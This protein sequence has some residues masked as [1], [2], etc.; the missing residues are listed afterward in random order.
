MSIDS[1]LLYIPDYCCTF[2]KQREFIV[3]HR[4]DVIDARVVNYMVDSDHV[5]TRSYVIKVRPY[6]D[7]YSSVHTGTL[8]CDGHSAHR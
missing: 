4:E 7:R 3:F 5:R 8:T 6:C 2:N 1:I